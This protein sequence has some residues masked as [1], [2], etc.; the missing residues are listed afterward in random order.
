MKLTIV[1]V[2]TDYAALLIQLYAT[3][4]FHFQQSDNGYLMSGFAFMRSLFLIFIFPRIIGRGRRWYLRRH[5]GR[6]AA[7]AGRTGNTKPPNGQPPR[8]EEFPATHPEEIDAPMDTQPDGE[9]LEPKPVEAD[10]DTTFDLFFL[11]W[12]LVVDGALTMGT[13]FATQKW[14]IY[15]GKNFTLRPNMALC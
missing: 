12:S 9:P 3:T 14:H 5:P 8:P 4:M 1:Q 10:E 11:R 2:A 7:R 13:A 15:L 6:A